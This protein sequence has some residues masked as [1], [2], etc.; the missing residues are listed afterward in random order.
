MLDRRRRRDALD[1]DACA[2]VGA[3]LDDGAA[4]RSTANA[5]TWVVLDD[6]AAT[7]AT[8]ATALAPTWAPRS[9]TAPRRG[10]QRQRCAVLDDDALD[11]ERQRASTCAHMGAVLDDAAATRS[12][13]RFTGCESQQA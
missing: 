4:T 6:G 7:R 5:V 12:S 10:R 2:H 13:R 8:R 11:G 3:V 9:T 1:N